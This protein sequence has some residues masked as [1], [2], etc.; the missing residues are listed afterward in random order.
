[1]LPLL[2]ILCKEQVELRF[3]AG[4]HRDGQTYIPPDIVDAEDIMARY[5]PALTSP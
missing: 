3:N 4:W 2:L 1:M 5:P